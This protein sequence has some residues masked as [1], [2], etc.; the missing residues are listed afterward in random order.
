MQS[1][2][3]LGDAVFTCIC[4]SLSF[5]NDFI[6]HP[7]GAPIT[8]FFKVCLDEKQSIASAV[9]H[10]LGVNASGIFIENGMFSIN[11]DYITFIQCSL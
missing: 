2:I 4:I 8:S 3:S 6:P 11:R 10:F 5:G 9:E 1:S 7:R